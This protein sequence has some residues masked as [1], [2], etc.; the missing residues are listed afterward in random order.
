MGLEFG[1]ARR[2]ERCISKRKRERQGE[3]ER[4]RTVSAKS[5]WLHWSNFL[6]PQWLSTSKVQFF[7]MRSTGDMELWSLSCQHHLLDLRFPRSAL[8][9]KR[10]KKQAQ[11]LIAA[12]A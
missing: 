9:E 12:S 8:Q 6:K 2:R 1:W 5:A 10:G 4:V 11:Q 7:L 3:K